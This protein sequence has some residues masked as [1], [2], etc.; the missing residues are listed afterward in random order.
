M[1]CDFYKKKS[2]FHKLNIDIVYNN[3]NLNNQIFNDRLTIYIS[4]L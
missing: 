4:P 2:K 1:N 3:Y